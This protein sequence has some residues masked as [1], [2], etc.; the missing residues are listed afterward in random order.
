MPLIH[1]QYK[2]LIHFEE[3][4]TK[5]ILLSKKISLREINISFPNHSTKLHKTV[6]YLGC[7]L[8]SKLFV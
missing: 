2:L 6:E 8:D 4:K 5:S 1:R 7:Q 3:E